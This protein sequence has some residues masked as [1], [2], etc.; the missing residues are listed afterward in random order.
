MLRH[1]KHRGQ[2]SARDPSTGSGWQA[3]YLYCHF[4]FRVSGH[5]GR[6]KTLVIQ[7]INSNNKPHRRS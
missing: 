5:D 1:S 4:S 2:A 6:V 7:P 3:P